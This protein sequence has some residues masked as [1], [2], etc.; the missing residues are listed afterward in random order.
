MKNDKYNKY[1]EQ[2]IKDFYT[3]EIKI[4]CFL[5]NYKNFIEFLHNSNKFEIKL[6]N[7][8]KFTRLLQDYIFLNVD[9][10]YNSGTFEDITLNDDIFF[11]NLNNY[12]FY[13]KEFCYNYLNYLDDFEIFQLQEDIKKDIN[14]NK[15][16][17]NLHNYFLNLINE[18][19]SICTD[20]FVGGRYSNLN[21][22]YDECYN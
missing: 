4:K 14:N 9:Y 21:L 5:L 12:E 20:D 13:N 3:V 6:T 10:C 19:N 22:L 8:H 18:Y 7:G 17:D 11:K 1:I 2:L 15:F 16:N